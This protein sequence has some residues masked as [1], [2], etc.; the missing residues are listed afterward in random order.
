VESLYEKLEGEV[1]NSTLQAACRCSKEGKL[2]EMPGN[3]R[4]A[5]G[6]CART[7]PVFVLYEKSSGFIVTQS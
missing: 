4:S 1:L 2:S 3:L 5:A 7:N 6:L